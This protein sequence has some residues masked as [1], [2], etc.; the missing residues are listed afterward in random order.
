MSGVGRRQFITLLGGA[1]V[2]WPRQSFCD[3][4]SHRRPEHSHLQS[5]CK[6]QA[7]YDE[8]AGQHTNRDQSAFAL[9]LHNKRPTV[10]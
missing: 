3:E 2:A 4:L 9:A 6:H 5:A 1:A 10:G 7:D 8:G